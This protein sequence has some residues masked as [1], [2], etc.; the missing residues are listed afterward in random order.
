MRNHF[1]EFL[2][3]SPCKTTNAPKKSLNNGIKFQLFISY[4]QRKNSNETTPLN[5]NEQ[6]QILNIY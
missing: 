2:N 4:I 5:K 1:A 3:F 6:N